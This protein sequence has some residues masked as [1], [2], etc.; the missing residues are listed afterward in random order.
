M[1]RKTTAK[2]VLSSLHALRERRYVGD[3]SASDTLIDLSSAINDANLT[4]RQIEALELV[5]VKD[6]TQKSAGEQMGVGQ[7]T[8][9]MLISR[10]VEAIYDAMPQ[11]FEEVIGMG[12][13]NKVFNVRATDDVA[14]EMEEM[15]RVPCV[16]FGKV[17]ENAKIKIVPSSTTARWTNLQL[18]ERSF[19]GTVTLINMSNPD[20]FRDFIEGYP[21]G[22]YKE[23]STTLEGGI[24]EETKRSSV[25]FNY[26][27]QDVPYF[28][29]KGDVIAR[30]EVYLD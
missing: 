21:D 28:V 8:V 13:P 29:R 30:V 15:K 25:D 18:L 3:L 5:Y 26:E 2:E 19:D 6:L 7:N 1:K 17:P 16:I 12:N 4:E 9:S 20:N 10:A 23:F 22:S 14:I 11:T 27:V 24:E